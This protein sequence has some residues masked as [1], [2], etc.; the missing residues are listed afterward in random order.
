M[1]GDL[2]QVVDNDDNITIDISENIKADADGVN[3]TEPESNDFKGN[4][5]DVT[6]LIA[7]VIG[8]TIL[9]TC[10]TCNL[11]LYIYPFLAILLGVIGVIMAKE[12]VNPERTQLWSW[13]SIGSGLIIILLSI[14]GIALYIIFVI[15]IV[16]VT[17]Y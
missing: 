3:E 8:I 16:R 13:L 11:T 15:F 4:A 2:A 10:L 12:S 17:G 1:T 6:S 5:Y 14:L 9:L 7:L